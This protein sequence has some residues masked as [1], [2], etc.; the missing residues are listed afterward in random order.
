MK[1]T[2]RTRRAAAAIATV[3]VIGGGG[4]AVG[5][6]VAGP[7]PQVSSATTAPPRQGDRAGYSDIVR[8]VRPSVVQI[9][10]TEGLGSGVILDDLG[11]IVTNAHVAGNATTFT[12]QLADDTKPRTAE[13][14]GT[15]PA[16][17]I[18]VIRADGL[19]GLRPA[20]FGD[21][22]KAQV[23]D[24]VLAVGNP[25]GLSSS[26]TDG[27]VSATGR[28]VSE[29]A[30]EGSSGTV[31]ADAIQTSAPINPGNSGGALVNASGQVIGIPTLAAAGSAGG[32][33]AQGIG[34]AIPSNTA[35]D[36]AT[37][38]IRSGHV[39]ST[40]RAA[41]GVQVATVTGTDGRAGGAGIVAVTGGGPAERAG[42][43]AGDAITAIG[44]SPTPDT[45]ALAEALADRDPGQDVAVSVVRDG[46][47]MTVH[48]TLGELPG[49]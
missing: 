27:I 16:G 43:R 48:V 37:Q 26:V 44:D 12:V 18:A 10:T 17:D 22:N 25:L 11:N 39:T 1:V 15:Y 4:V 36:I 34:F 19:S 23:G 2:Q 24:A 21:S 6:A 14:V 31:L 38:L 9:R 46:R 29:P 40:G 28:T 32:A 41:I 3:A 20:S 5:A 35:R 49:G 42:L 30:S 7:Q 47:T 8:Q 33:Q 13:L 45:A